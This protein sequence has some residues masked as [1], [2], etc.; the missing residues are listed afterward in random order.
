MQFLTKNS[1]NININIGYDDKQ[2]LNTTYIKLLGIMTD[3]TLAWKTH[4]EKNTVKLSSACYAVRA[5]KHFLSQDILKMMYTSDF[6]S[7]MKYGIILWGISTYNKNIFRL[8]KRVIR[9]IMGVGTRLS[10]REFFKILNI[11]PLNSQY[12]FHIYF[13]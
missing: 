8:Q 9:F 1:S 5:I 4:I 11:L 6:L 2:I 12:F 3:D 13:S 7:I 10:C